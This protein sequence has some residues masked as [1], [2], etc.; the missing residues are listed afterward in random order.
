MKSFSAQLSSAKLSSVQFSSVWLCF[1]GL[2][3]SLAY[4]HHLS[5]HISSEKSGA[6]NGQKHRRRMPK[7]NFPFLPSNIC[8]LWFGPKT[9]DVFLLL[10]RSSKHTIFIFDISKTKAQKQQFNSQR[11]NRNIC[12]WWYGIK[13]SEWWRKNCTNGRRCSLTAMVHNYV[14]KIIF[15]GFARSCCIIWHASDHQ[16]FWILIVLFRNCHSISFERNLDAYQRFWKYRDR[17]SE[18]VCEMGREEHM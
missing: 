1:I 13:F 14:R 12:V 8:G 6:N 7:Q 18:R 3:Y 5:A 15:F 16:W 10:I 9:V 2:K 11:V 17:K 4:N